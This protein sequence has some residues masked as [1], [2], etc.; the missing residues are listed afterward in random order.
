MYVCTR[1]VPNTDELNGPH[2]KGGPLYAY[3]AP[4]GRLSGRGRMA[5]GCCSYCLLCMLFLA[6]MCAVSRVSRV[7]GR[8]I[9]GLQANEGD[10]GDRSST[11]QSLPLYYPVVVLVMLVEPARRRAARAGP[12]YYDVRIFLFFHPHATVYS[13]LSQRLSVASTD[14]GSF[15]LRT[16]VLSRYCASILARTLADYSLSVE[17]TL[18][19]FPFRV[20]SES[21]IPNPK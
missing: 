20:T 11:P 21:K 1:K 2:R 18:K 10:T 5:D 9:C 16:T 14:G 19:L 17:S 4:A 3:A 8:G 13:T 7:E 6:C 12:L 15:P